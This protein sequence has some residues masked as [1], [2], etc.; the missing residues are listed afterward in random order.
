M[1]NQYIYEWKCIEPLDNTYKD[2]KRVQEFTNRNLNKHEQYEN[3]H[4]KSNQPGKLFATAKTNLFDSANDND[5]LK[6]GQIIN[7]E[8]TGRYVYNAS[9]VV[10]K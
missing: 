1:I 5:Q 3:M 10:S 2:L 9:K 8:L 4:R 7:C 6:L